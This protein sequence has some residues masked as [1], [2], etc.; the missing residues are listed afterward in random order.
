MFRLA[1]AATLFCNEFDEGY[2]P[3]VGQDNG[4]KE[5]GDDQR[6]DWGVIAVHF[7]RIIEI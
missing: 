3:V 4:C 7:E 1:A 6:Q 5:D 2:V